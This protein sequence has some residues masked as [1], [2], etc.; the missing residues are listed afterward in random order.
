MWDLGPSSIFSLY[1]EMRRLR[2]LHN[3]PF[4]PEGVGQVL[5]LKVPQV[6]TMRRD[7]QRQMLHKE[8]GSI[9]QG[10]LLQVR[11]LIQIVQIMVRSY[12]GPVYHLSPFCNS[13]LVDCRYIKILA[14]ALLYCHLRL[15]THIILECPRLRELRTKI[16]RNH[17][18]ELIVRS[19]EAS[20]LVSF[21]TVEHIAAMEQED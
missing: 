18:A 11:K 6:L 9:L 4:H 8:L 12:W 21:L 1:S 5:A 13:L 16:F 17:R 20:Q 2:P 15:E 14:I 7:P 3:G 10:W 19:W